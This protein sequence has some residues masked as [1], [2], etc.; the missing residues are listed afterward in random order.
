MEDEQKEARPRGR[1]CLED[2]KRTR[3]VSVRMMESDFQ[4]LEALRA[5]RSVNQVVIDLIRGARIKPALEIPHGL[6]SSSNE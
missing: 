5:G 6:K 1:P 4:A 3:R 2:R